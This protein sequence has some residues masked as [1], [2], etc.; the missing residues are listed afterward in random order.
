MEMGECVRGGADKDRVDGGVGQDVV[1]IAISRDA[2]G[3]GDR[4]GCRRI[5]IGN[6]DQLRARDAAFQIVGMEPA[7][8]ARADDSNSQ[9]VHSFVLS[10]I[11]QVRFSVE[12]VDEA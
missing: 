10:L 9:C 12:A 5:D 11:T 7:D 6:S 4:F 8:A 3:G 2:Q 1:I